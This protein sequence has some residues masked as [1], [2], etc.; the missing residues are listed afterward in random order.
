MHNG[1]QKYFLHFLIEHQM[2]T[3]FDTLFTEP[4]FQALIARE[5][6][7]LESVLFKAIQEFKHGGEERKHYVDTLL[8]MIDGEMAR[9]LLDQF[10]ERVLQLKE[11]SIDH[12]YAVK[13]MLS[14]SN[15][16]PEGIVRLFGQLNQCL[17]ILQSRS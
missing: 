8:D 10:K 2:K 14:V 15:L 17:R 7:V 16:G 9:T 5:T 3:V 11:P 4:R 1:E 13:T 12:L 6:E